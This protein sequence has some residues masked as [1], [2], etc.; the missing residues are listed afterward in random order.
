MTASLPITGDYFTNFGPLR[1]EA[2]GD[3]VQG[4]YPHQDGE[5]EATLHGDRLRGTW[6]QRA[7]GRTGELDLRFDRGANNFEGKWRFHGDELD[8]GSWS[9]VRLSLPSEAEGGFPGALNSHSDGPVFAGPMIGETSDK[10]AR[11]WIQ[12]RDTSP[13][14]LVVESARGARRFVATP[15]WDEWLCLVFNADD[16]DPSVPHTYFVESAHGRTP[17][18][19]LRLAPPRSARSARVA[20]GSCFH[21]YHKRNLPIFG[22]IAADEPSVF[23]MLGDNTYYYEPDWQSEHTMMLAQLRSRNN[24]SLRNLLT[25]VPTIGVLDDHDFGP[26]NCDSTFPG[27]DRALRV[28]RRCFAQSRYGAKGVPGIFSSVRVGPAEVFLLDSRSY[29]VT[30][31][32]TVLGAAQLQW[33]VESLAASDAPVKVIASPTQVLPEF[34]IQQN[35]ESFRRDAPEEL[36]GLLGEIEARGIAGVV[37]ASG[38]L[39]MANLLR[40]QGRPREYWEL[41]T[42]PLANDPYNGPLLG[43]DSTLVKEV[44]DRC[45]YGIIDIDLDRAG[46][47]VVL[48][49]R[50]EKGEVLFDQPL[51]LSKLAVC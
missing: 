39:H 23:V 24:D 28:F 21:F 20:L 19:P 18:F 51:A 16:L 48:S 35:W 1:L 6:T 9:G 42:S 8:R 37:F 34:P 25:T 26:N 33:L 22:A 4:T 27:K 15:R 44:V 10:G 38:D 13:V 2:R 49:L 29:R 3:Q 40:L 7:N 36:E 14:T 50:D 30:S 31:E 43:S 32:R 46:S 17:S 12:A 41:T 11:I 45:N 5:L 47:E